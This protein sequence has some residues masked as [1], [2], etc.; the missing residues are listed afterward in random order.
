MHW[1]RRKH[2][3]PDQTV[4]GKPDELRSA[5]CEHGRLLVGAVRRIGMVACTDG[6][7]TARRMRTRAVQSLDRSA[8]DD[9]FGGIAQRPEHI[10]RRPSEL[11]KP[12]FDSN[13]ESEGHRSRAAYW[14]YGQSLAGF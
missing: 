4:P 2:G 9:P 12:G 6:S 1:W 7:D 3:Y 13:V 11:G 5:F 8:A 14:V 10:A